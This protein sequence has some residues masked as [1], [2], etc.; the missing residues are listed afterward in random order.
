MLLLTYYCVRQI[1]HSFLHSSVIS[2]VR[3]RRSIKSIE[4]LLC[5]AKS[6]PKASQNVRKKERKK[7]L[8][9]QSKQGATVARKNSSHWKKPTAD[10][11]FR[12]PSSLIK[13]VFTI[14]KE[15]HK[16]IYKY[17][18]SFCVVQNTSNSLEIYLSPDVKR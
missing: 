10:P 12:E 7:E 2:Q 15:I 14:Q 5:S 3:A 18:K 9:P 4:Q 13:N 16:N 1:N 11:D 17:I 6:L 8:G